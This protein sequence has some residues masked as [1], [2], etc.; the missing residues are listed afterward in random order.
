MLGPV[1]RIGEQFFVEPI[2][3]RQIEPRGLV[4]EKQAQ[5]VREELPDHFLEQLVVVG[6]VSHA[7]RLL[8]RHALRQ[9]P[10]FVDV[11]AAEYG[12]FVGE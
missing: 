11:A 4:G 2:H 5:E 6:G 1:G 8:H 3:A 7:N 9:V 12:D 10:R